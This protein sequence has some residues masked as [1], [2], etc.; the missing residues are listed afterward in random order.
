MHVNLR[1]RERERQRQEGQKETE[2][3]GEIDRKSEYQIE[4]ESGADRQT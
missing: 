1:G 3:E 4:N 2:R